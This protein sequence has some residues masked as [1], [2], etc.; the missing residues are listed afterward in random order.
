MNQKIL[1]KLTTKRYEQAVKVIENIH[2]TV[3]DLSYEIRVT[4]DN[5]WTDNL[6]KACRSSMVRLFASDHANK[7]SAINSDINHMDWD[8]LVNVS[9]D[10]LFIVQGFDDIIR[11]EFDK[12]GTND[13][14]LHFPDGNRKDFSTM[15]I[16]GREYYERDKYIYNPAYLSLC[17]DVE[18]TEVA[19]T[20]GCY[21][22]CDT[23]IFEHNHPS[24]HKG[25]MDELYIKNNT[26]MTDKRTLDYRKRNNYFL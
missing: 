13:L 4:A 21:R 10:N 12:A 9:D 18:A 8:I 11:E 23:Q 19:K 1:F 16:M 26:F 22:Y 14:F 3:A 2:A 5:D 15:S 6:L 7:V 20:R 17:A 25:K 24:F